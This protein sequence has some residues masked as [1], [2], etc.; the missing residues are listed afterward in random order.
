MANKLNFKNK[1]FPLIAVKFGVF[2]EEIWPQVPEKSRLCSFR[3]T[4]MSGIVLQAIQAVRRRN[5]QP[6]AERL[7]REKKITLQASERIK[8]RILVHWMESHALKSLKR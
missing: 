7:F 6:I 8:K 5:F 2:T 1:F 3:Y 4:Y